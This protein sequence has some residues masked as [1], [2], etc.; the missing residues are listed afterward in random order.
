VQGE[1]GGGGQYGRAEVLHDL[2]LEGGRDGGRGGESGAEQFGGVVEGE[3]SGK[4]AEV[5]GH[6]DDVPL[7]DSQLFVQTHHQG[8]PHPDVMA[9]EAD[10]DGA[11]LIEPCRIADFQPND[12]L[13]RFGKEAVRV[14]GGKVLTGGEGELGKSVDGGNILGQELQCVHPP[15]VEIHVE[16]GAVECH[17]QLFHLQLADFLAGPVSDRCLGHVIP[18]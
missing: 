5:E 4:E 16:I 11:V 17:L 2:Q 8:L 7:P 10:D 1:S 6:L 14:V 3:G 15:T 12:A 18:P 9:G 13:E